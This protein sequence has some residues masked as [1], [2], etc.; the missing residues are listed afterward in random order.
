MPTSRI[1]FAHPCKRHTDIL[2]AASHNVEFTTFDTDSELDKIA[3]HNPR[4]ASL[5]IPRGSSG[6]LEGVG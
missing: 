6:L 4:C 2:Y 1:I 3:E 5:L